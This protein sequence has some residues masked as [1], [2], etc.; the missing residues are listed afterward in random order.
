MHFTY[1]IC[2]C[3]Y[4]MS[5]IMIGYV[6]YSICFSIYDMSAIMNISILTSLAR[7]CLHNDLTGK[8]IKQTNKQYL[9][10]LP[11][12]QVQAFPLLSIHQFRWGLSYF[13]TQIY[14][15]GI[16]MCT[17]LYHSC[18]KLMICSRSILIIPQYE[19]IS[20]PHH[21][22]QLSSPHVDLPGDQQMHR[23]EDRLG[24]I[25][26]EYVLGRNVSGGNDSTIVQED[27]IPLVLCSRAFCNCSFYIIIYHACS[28]SY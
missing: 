15:F 7:S 18:S 28:T 14:L 26:E 21:Q 17:I 9:Y 8:Q 6:K 25:R 5:A 10:S 1:L 20:P 2:V 16:N 13:H 3:I 19:N 27:I 11:S 22:V 23:L 4:H 12:Q 24:K